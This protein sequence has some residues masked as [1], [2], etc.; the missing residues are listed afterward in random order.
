M[1]TS[2]NVYCLLLVHISIQIDPFSRAKTLYYD[3]LN[4]ILYYQGYLL[5]SIVHCAYLPEK[6][7]AVECSVS[8]LD[9]FAGHLGLHQGLH[10]L[11]FSSHFKCG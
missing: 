9:N 8:S 7:C 1:P 2:I 3:D 5:H 10:G 4:V 6:S 11:H